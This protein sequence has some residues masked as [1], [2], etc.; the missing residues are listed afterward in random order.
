MST[1]S[2]WAKLSDAD[3][4]GV[5]KAMGTYGGSFASRLADAWARAD[6]INSARLGYAFDDLVLEYAPGSPAFEEANK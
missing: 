6:A 1:Q 3:R 4:Y 5:L 2:T